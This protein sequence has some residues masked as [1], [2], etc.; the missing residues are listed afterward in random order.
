M[1]RGP[2]FNKNVQIRSLNNVDIHHIACHIL[3]LNRN[4]YAT[5]GSLVNLISLFLPIKLFQQQ[6]PDQVVRQQKV[7]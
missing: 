4:K 1:A 2:S 6:H 5:A 7:Q 3:K